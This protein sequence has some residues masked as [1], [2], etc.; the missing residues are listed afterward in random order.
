MLPLY[1]KHSNFSSFARQLNFYGF[2]KLRSDPILTSEEDADT[3]SFVRFYHEKFQ[4]DKPDLLH[5]IKRATKTDQQSSKDDVDQLKMEVTKLRDDLAAATNEYNR[6]ITELSYECN[7]R[8]TSM[9]AE[10][11]KLMIL[12]QRT[13]GVMI[14]PASSS[15]TTAA[16]LQHAS[17]SANQPA[18]SPQADLLYSLSQAAMLQSHLRAPSDACLNGNRVKDEVSYSEANNKRFKG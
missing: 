13:I 1:F 9:N 18:P 6:K 14:T 16:V 15:S 3:S 7:R 2:R 10:F 5:E 17:S 12:V 8:I 4:R 11:D